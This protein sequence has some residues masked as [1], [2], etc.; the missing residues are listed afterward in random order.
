[1]KIFNS[2]TG[3]VFLCLM[4]ILPYCKKDDVIPSTTDD[5]I[6][7]IKNDASLSIYYLIA[8]RA[9]AESYINSSSGILAPIDNAFISAGITPNTVSSFSQAYSDS[10]IKYMSVPSGMS[11]NGVVGTRV[12]FVS[13]LGLPVYGDSTATNVY[14]NGVSTASVTPTRG[15]NTSIY[16]LNKVLD[17]PYPTISQFISR[18]SS[19]SFYN[20]AFT[21]ANWSASLT[22][23]TYTLFAPTNDAFRSA[24]YVDIQSIDSVNMNT[25]TQLL[26][27]N[28]AQNYYYL[29]DLATQSNITTLQGGAITLT[30][31]DGSIILT[32]IT[33]PS[34]ATILNSGSLAG[35]ALVY[36][37]SKILLP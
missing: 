19:L 25:L 35:N 8:T 24:G 3:F 6:T 9:N 14:F 23:G 37:V 7:V 31:T 16:K 21:R 32:G 34:P 1:M 36:K 12:N 10:L 22:G 20:E 26:K 30:N 13:G 15:Y 4:C 18:D 28:T 2:I 27:F 11:F 5:A 33:N 29:N 17:L